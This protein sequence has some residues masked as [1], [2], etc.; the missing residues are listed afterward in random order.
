[1]KIRNIEN[2]KKEYLELLLLADEQE[3]MVD[4]YLERGTMFVFEKDGKLI[5]ECVLTDEG[6]GIAEIKNL[7]V[8]PEE[9]RKG[10]GKAIIDMIAD[11]CHG[12]FDT[13]QVGTGDSLLTIPFYES[14]GFVRHSVIPQ[15]FTQNYNHPIFEDGKLLDD[16]IVLRKKL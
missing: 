13:L 6:F 15:F 10:Y 9:Q 16:M 12:K 3:D 5:G 14:C 11:Y 1:M 7:A 4:R 2:N 8:V